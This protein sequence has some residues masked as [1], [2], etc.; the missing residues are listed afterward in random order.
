MSSFSSQFSDIPSA[1][2]AIVAVVVRVVLQNYSCA[3]VESFKL[4]VR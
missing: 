4:V 2:S 3:G 1:F